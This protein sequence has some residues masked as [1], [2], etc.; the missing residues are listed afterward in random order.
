MPDSSAVVFIAF[1]VLSLC[2]V[3]ALCVFAS[4]WFSPL[5]RFLLRAFKRVNISRGLTSNH[6]YDSYDSY[7]LDLD[8]DLNSGRESENL[9]LIHI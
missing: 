9:S 6:A 8:S 4:D 2:V 3:L 5:W 1:G 7:D